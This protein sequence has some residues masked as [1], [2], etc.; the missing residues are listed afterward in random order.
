MDHNKTAQWNLENVYEPNISINS[1]AYPYRV[2]GFVGE[3][4]ELAIIL[5]LSKEHE[6]CAQAEFYIAL[7]LLVTIK[8]IE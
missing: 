3:G 7:H 4:D 6:S 2:S 5:R 8:V 1:K